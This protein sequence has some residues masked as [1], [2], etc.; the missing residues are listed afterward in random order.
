MSQPKPAEHG[1]APTETDP[2]V[3]FRARRFGPDDV[4]VYVE[5]E[6]GAAI[7]IDLGADF[8]AYAAGT[9]VVGGIATTV[10]GTVETACRLEAIDDLI[11]PERPVLRLA[12][13]APTLAD[14]SEA[15]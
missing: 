9:A 12:H 13:P 15:A 10:E 4:S 8:F 5:R 3:C 7:R 6:S 14:L 2:I 11:E 1:P